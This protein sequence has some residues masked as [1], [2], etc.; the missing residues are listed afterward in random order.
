MDPVGVEPYN[1]AIFSGVL[2]QLSYGSINGQ[3]Y[4]HGAKLG[5]GLEPATS[6]LAR[7]RSTAELPELCEI[8]VG[9]LEPP[10]FRRLFLTLYRLS[11]TPLVKGP[12]KGSNLQPRGVSPCSAN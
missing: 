11:Y 10:T 9:G 1:L 5:A 6:S 3:R 12:G 8:E 7:L 2:C 4:I